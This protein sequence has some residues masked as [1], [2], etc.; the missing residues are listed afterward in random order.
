MQEML[1]AKDLT[2]FDSRWQPIGSKRDFIDDIAVA[3]KIDARYLT[4]NNHRS[5]CTAVKMSWLSKRETKFDED[6]AYCMLGLFD[7]RLDVR[8][9]EGGEQAFLR[10]QHALLKK[11]P[12]D[13]S[14]FA[15]IGAPN[16]LSASGLL[17][18]WPAHFAGCG[19]I[20]SV[21]AEDSN[22]MLIPQVSTDESS[23]GVQIPA[24][25]YNLNNGAD[26]NNANAANMID[27]SLLLHCRQPQPAQDKKKSEQDKKKP[28]DYIFLQMVRNQ[29]GVWRRVPSKTFAL[30]PLPK[31]SKGST[32]MVVPQS[33]AFDDF[34]EVQQAKKKGLFGRMRVGMKA[35]IDAQTGRG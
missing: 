4:G 33:A 6:M 9:G 11:R 3:S 29:Q 26:W 16:G 13:E 12:Q 18:P 1:A 19:S 25:H 34:D 5:A 7:V 8:Y 30:G 10:L 20:S 22:D 28:E 32:T 27:H 35:A 31:S 24:K 23:I 21:P 2:L 15:W 14:I 17:A